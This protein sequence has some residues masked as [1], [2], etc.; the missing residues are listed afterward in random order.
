[1]QLFTSS[2]LVIRYLLYLIR[3]IHQL[4]HTFAFTYLSR[5]PHAGKFQQC[6][7]LFTFSI[8]GSFSEDTLTMPLYINCTTVCKSSNFTSFKITI[9]CWHGLTLNNDWKQSEQAES[10]IL[11]ACKFLPSAARVTST[12]VS[13]WQSPVK[14]DTKLTGW[15]FHLKQNEK[16][17]L[18]FCYALPTILN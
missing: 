18:S 2:T 13:E 4:S 6:S 10:S 8:S 1:M 17:R 12:R 11:W 15:L 16:K 14:T 7:G 3:I 5:Y 9:G